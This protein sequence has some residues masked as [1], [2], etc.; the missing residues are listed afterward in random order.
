M[1]G[2]AEGPESAETATVNEASEAEA[3]VSEKKGSLDEEEEEE[4][5]ETRGL[6][7]H[8]VEVS[9]NGEGAVYSLFGDDETDSDSQ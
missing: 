6:L 5:E 8:F 9:K 4:D 7:K 3:E 2:V 1:N